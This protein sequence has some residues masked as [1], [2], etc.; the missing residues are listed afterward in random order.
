M[1]V[2]VA[3]SPVIVADITTITDRWK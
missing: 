2:C 3:S 1:A